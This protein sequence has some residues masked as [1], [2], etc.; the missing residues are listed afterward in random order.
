MNCRILISETKNILGWAPSGS[1][2]TFRPSYTTHTKHSRDISQVQTLSFVRTKLVGEMYCYGTVWP[3]SSWLHTGQFSA[4]SP[5]E[6]HW[7]H[8]SLTCWDCG[9]AGHQTQTSSHCQ[10]DGAAGWASVSGG[11]V[12]HAGPVSTTGA[13]TLLWPQ[14]RPPASPQPQ[15]YHYTREYFGQNKAGHWPEINTRDS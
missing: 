1:A 3:I 14:P 12:P 11:R 7:P 8:S 9:Q 5:L 6:A 15:H 13:Y 2:V 4:N 10:H